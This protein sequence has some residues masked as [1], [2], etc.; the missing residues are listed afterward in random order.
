MRYAAIVAVL[1]MIGACTTTKKKS[2]S[3]A[4][5]EAPAKAAAVEAVTKT[6]TSKSSNGSSEG[7]TLVCLSGD[8]KRTIIHTATPEVVDGDTRKC[9]V[10]YSK[11]N[12]NDVVAYA[13]HQEEYCSDVFW[14]IQKN[15]QDGGFKCVVQ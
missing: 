14:K 12:T 2:E 3:D 4:T 8:D 5:Q 15:L 1:F 13:H 9:Q 6:E 10:S 7:K 11:F